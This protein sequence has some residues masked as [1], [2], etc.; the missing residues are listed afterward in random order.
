[1]SYECL[2]GKNS[3]IMHEAMGFR[4]L[5]QLLKTIYED[6]DDHVTL[7]GNF[8][9][10]YRDKMTE[11]DAF[12]IK[13][14]A[15]II[16]DLKA[17]DG[18]L[19][20]AS[21]K[22][23]WVCID[24]NERE[25]IIKGGNG[26]KNP[27]EQVMR[28]QETFINYFYDFKTII[29]GLRHAQ[30]MVY[31]SDEMQ[32]IKQLWQ[33]NFSNKRKRF[34][35][36]DI[37]HVLNDVRDTSN[38]EILISEQHIQFI[39]ETLKVERF[40][41]ENPYETIKSYRINELTIA[42]QKAEEKASKFEDMAIKLGDEAKEKDEVL[43]K[44][45]A[46]EK[47]LEE[48]NRRLEEKNKKLEED[49]IK[50][51]INKNEIVSFGDEQILATKGGRE[52]T[53]SSSSLLIEVNDNVP[54]GRNKNLC[55]EL[56]FSSGQ[57]K[58]IKIDTFDPK[59]I[60]TN[61]AKFLIGKNTKVSTWIG[62]DVNWEKLGYFNNIYESDQ[63]TEPNKIIPYSTP[64]NVKILKVSLVNGIKFKSNWSK[65]M[66]EV[67]TDLGTFIA[68]TIQHHQDLRKQ[69]RFVEWDKEQGKIVRI[70]SRRDSQNPSLY[71]INFYPE[72][73]NINV[74]SNKSSGQKKPTEVTTNNIDN[75]KTPP[76]AGKKWEPH[77]ETELRELFLEQEYD[78]GQIALKFGRTEG[79]IS[80]RLQ[81]MELIDEDGNYT[82]ESQKSSFDIK[83]DHSEG[84]WINDF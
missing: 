12:I 36:T 4:A 55:T 74:S 2:V 40:E 6:H 80:S 30:G 14:N 68:A 19:T 26:Q 11:I 70:W 61:K 34:L 62:G 16:I 52:I 5:N 73:T 3:Q 57:K 48:E 8:Y 81:K 15:L 64:R 69:G 7:I 77:E 50:Q 24:R 72:Q 46:K 42:Q 25:V 20:Q 38:P 17:Y 78:I 22:G 27:Y 58:Y 31:F 65:P 76:N 44:K 32:D 47:A 59:L 54:R 29:P 60:I 1:M 82:S 23:D 66:Y 39:I 43:K 21:E 33:R 49:L 41:D 10:N 28:N 18:M 79:S 45:E 53:Y 35:I 56:I 63:P 71:W 13:K 83:E 84:D 67:E 75:V 37:N 51:G 9:I